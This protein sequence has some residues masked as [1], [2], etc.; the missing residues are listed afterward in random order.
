MLAHGY[1]L[2]E[3]GTLVQLTVCEEQKR[4][5]EL[6][7]V[8]VVMDT[9]G[10][11]GNLVATVLNTAIPDAMLQSGYDI[12]TPIDVITFANYAL[13]MKL[14]ETNSNSANTTI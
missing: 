13:I 12:D 2:G 5:P 1:R 9:S 11:M 10:S 3:L 7:H 6:P 8:V 14:D 4:N